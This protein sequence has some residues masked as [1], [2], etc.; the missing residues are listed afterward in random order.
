ML[1]ACGIGFSASVAVP[2]SL[3]SDTGKKLPNLNAPAFG[4]V[5]VFGP[6]AGDP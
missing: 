4:K 5:R 2:I 6:M 3:A 1:A